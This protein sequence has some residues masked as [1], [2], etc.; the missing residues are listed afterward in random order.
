MTKPA[1]P[2]KQLTFDS[3]PSAAVSPKQVTDNKQETPKKIVITQMEAVT[4]IEELTLKT[5][6]RLQPSRLLFSKVKAD[7]FFENT[8]ISSV[9]IRVLQ[10]PLG[11]DESE[12]SWVLDT[13]DLGAGVYRLRLE[14]YEWWQTGER[15]SQTSRE[16]TLDYKPVTRQSRL[17]KIPTVKSVAGADLTV[18]SGTEKEVF[19][20]LNENMKK[21][22]LNR[23]DKY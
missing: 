5:A 20:E 1:K 17:I 8:N 22:Q 3:L 16:L 15:F 23:R 19:T 14:M 6:F 9:L 4:G 12:Y 2:P 13:K 21:E 11:S 18:V 7:L 10:G